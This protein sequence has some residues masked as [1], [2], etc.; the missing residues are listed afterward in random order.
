MNLKITPF[1][2]PTAA[3]ERLENCKVHE[4]KRM[5]SDLQLFKQLLEASKSLL[6]HY[7]YT[8]KK[9]TVI[10]YK[11]V[12]FILGILISFLG[13]YI[14]S[15]S[16]NFIASHLLSASFGT[17]VFIAMVSALLSSSAFYLAAR[18]QAHREIAIGFAKKA[19]NRA[20]R[21]YLRKVFYLQYQRTIEHAEIDDAKTSWKFLYED[22][23]EAIENK[24]EENLLLLERIYQSTVLSSEEKEKLFNQTLH[25]FQESLKRSLFQFESGV[26]ERV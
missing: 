17:K 7:P 11:A 19:K 25:A 26:S 9:G 3:F 1:D 21:I 10:F 12:F 20:K 14:C 4:Q 13:L 16:Y 8:M 15:T 23:I 24:Q 2:S 22:V 5:S 6:S 18:M